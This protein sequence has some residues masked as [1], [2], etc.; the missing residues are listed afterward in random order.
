[1]EIVVSEAKRDRARIGFIADASIKIHR[2]EVLDAIAKGENKPA[3]RP[4]IRI[5]EPLQE[6]RSCPQ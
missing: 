1:M 5:G 3:V 6:V 4:L 2:K